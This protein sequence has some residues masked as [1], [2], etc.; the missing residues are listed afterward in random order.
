[1]CDGV[2]C[3]ANIY[4]YTSV[5]VRCRR[6]RK[7]RAWWYKLCFICLIVFDVLCAMPSHLASS[8]HCSHCMSRDVTR[9]VNQKQCVFEYNVLCSLECGGLTFSIALSERLH[10]AQSMETSPSKQKQITPCSYRMLRT[11]IVWI[12]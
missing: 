7:G 3:L 12:Q 6:K 9:S 5:W 2:K 8:L 4:H 11:N 10:L 1:M